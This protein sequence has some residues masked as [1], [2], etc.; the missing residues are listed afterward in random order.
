MRRWL[1]WYWKKVSKGY[2]QGGF[3]PI[4]A[5]NV[6]GKLPDGIFGGLGLQPQEGPAKEAA[7]NYREH[8]ETLTGVSLRRCPVCHEG[9]MHV[10]ELLPPSPLQPSDGD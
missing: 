3:G 9:R 1:T 5:K 6:A 7:P 4:R 10:I 2:P 8:Y